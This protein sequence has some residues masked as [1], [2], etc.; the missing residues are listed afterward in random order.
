MAKP[1]ATSATRFSDF[2]L[3]LVE[4]VFRRCPPYVAWRVMAS[5]LRASGLRL[6]K[7]SVFWGMPTF[8]GAGQVSAL[9]TIGEHCG[10][11]LGCHFEVDDE[12]VIEDHVSVGHQVMFLTRRKTSG[13]TAPIRVGAGAWLGSRSV[14]MPGVTIGAGAVVGAAAVI[15]EDVPPNVLISGGRKISL[16]KWR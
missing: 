6:G 15:T 7:T 3:T 4:R 10:F 9:L 1:Q 8:S 2:G 5:L 11:N 14:V 12:I 16:A 13:D